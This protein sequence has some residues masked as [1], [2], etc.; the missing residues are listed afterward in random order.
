MVTRLAPRAW[1]RLRVR[2][3]A[4]A[5]SD[6]STIATQHHRLSLCQPPRPGSSDPPLDNV[7][8]ARS[9]SKA[10]C[11]PQLQLQARCSAC[12]THRL[13]QL[14]CPLSVEAAHTS[15]HPPTRR[16]VSMAGNTEFEKGNRSI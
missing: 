12:C 2:A 15:P 4:R 8:R 13:D 11:I 7:P 16:K 5:R 6:A 10:A 9:T 1:V 14:N 3:G